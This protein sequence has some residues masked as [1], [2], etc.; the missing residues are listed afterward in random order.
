MCAGVF[1]RVYVCLFVGISREYMFVGVEGVHACVAK[2]ERERAC[3]HASEREIK[4][5]TERERA[6]GRES[7]REIK[8]E[9]ERERKRAHARAQER[10][11][12][13]T[14]E[15]GADSHCHES[16]LNSK[17]SRLIL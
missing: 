5:E 3:K 11:R 17:S 12:E 16:P 7:E 6:R 15:W 13:Q 1:V 14:R 2:R 10:E 4:R 8:R 9:T